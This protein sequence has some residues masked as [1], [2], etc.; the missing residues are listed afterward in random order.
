M[1]AWSYIFEVSCSSVKMFSRFTNIPSLCLI[2]PHT[3]TTHPT[4]ELHIH[5]GKALISSLLA[6]LSVLPN[7]RQAEPGEFTRQALLGGRLD[8]TQ[9]EGLHDLIDAETEV[10]RAWAL[11]NAVVAIIIH[12]S[13]TTIE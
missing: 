3:Y 2:A 12:S 13:K 11:E 10:Q 5:S 9:V 1:K 7:L 8:L 4:V 6:S